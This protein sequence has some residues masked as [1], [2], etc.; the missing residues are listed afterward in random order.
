MVS[1]GA[2]DFGEEGVEEGAILCPH[3]GLDVEGA[4]GAELGAER[5]VEVEVL[6]HAEGRSGKNRNSKLER[7]EQKEAKVA[8]GGA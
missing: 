1:G 3:T 8:K 6:D 7:F 5:D 2:A 4:V